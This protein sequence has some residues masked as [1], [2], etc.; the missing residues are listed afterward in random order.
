MILQPAKNRHFVAVKASMG[1]ESIAF[2]KRQLP[3]FSHVSHAY[4]SVTLGN[5]SVSL[6]SVL[7]LILGARG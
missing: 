1:L 4:Q 2:Q 7:G 5:S 3:G 6:C